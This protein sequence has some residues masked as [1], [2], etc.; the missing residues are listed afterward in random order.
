MTVP[1]WVLLGFALWT[2]AVLMVGIGMRRWTLILTGNAQIKDFPGDTPHG[3][4]AYRRAV[5]AHANC[6]E[7]LPVYGAVSVALFASH[8][9]SPTADVLAIALLIARVGQSVVHMAFDETN[10]TVLIR[11]SFFFAQLLAMLWMAVEVIRL[12]QV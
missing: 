2:I 7:N 4:P 11:F 9:T 3:S 5:R 1:L 8:V 10:T 6:V 12:G